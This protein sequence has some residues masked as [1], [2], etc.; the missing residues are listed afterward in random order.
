MYATLGHALP[1]GDGWTYEELPT[2]HWPMFSRP[3]ELA[4]LLNKAY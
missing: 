3:A 1:R 4:D 2:W